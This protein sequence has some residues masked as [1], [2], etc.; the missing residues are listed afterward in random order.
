MGIILENPQFRLVIGSDCIAKS[1][2]HKKTG[3]E[4]LDPEEKVALFSVT[5][6]IKLV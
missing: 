3:R 6:A 2:I 5:N 4:C 1:L